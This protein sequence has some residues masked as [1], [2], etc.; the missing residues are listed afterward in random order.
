MT[1]AF[2]YTVKC[3][4]RRTLSIEVRRGQVIVRA[5]HRVSPEA[6]RQLVASKTPW[7]QRHLQR[8]RELLAAIPRYDFVS[9]CRLPYLGRELV[10]DCAPGEVAAVSL[11]GERLQILL[12]ARS[13]RPHAEQATQLV[14]N[15][16]RQQALA[17]LTAKSDQLAARLGLRHSGVAVKA[18]RSKWGHCTATG[19]LQYNWQIVLAP[20]P[21]VDYLVAHEVCHLRHHD[22]SPAFWQLVAS[23][24]PDYQRR[25]RWLREQGATLTL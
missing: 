20:E 18:T 21:I 14:R 8:Q 17:L 10:L 7:V 25:R 12:S 5:P 15:W 3:S 9:G 16:Y 19:R 4:A 6:V 11:H 2:P 24:C 22:H 13:R 1:S 23:V